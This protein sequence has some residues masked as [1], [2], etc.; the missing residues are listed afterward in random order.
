MWYT[1]AVLYL[2]TQVVHYPQDHGREP[3]HH[4]GVGLRHIV[5][6]SVSQEFLVQGPGLNG[7]DVGLDASLEKL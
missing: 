4:G 2:G 6:E 5:F 1:P 7:L 3:Q